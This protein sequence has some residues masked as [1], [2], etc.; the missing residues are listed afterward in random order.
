MNMSDA[1]QRRQILLER[2]RSVP[3]SQ[4][5]GET[6]TQQINAVRGFWLLDFGGHLLQKMRHFFLGHPEPRQLTSYCMD[7]LMLTSQEPIRVNHETV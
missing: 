5:Q 6:M 3:R 7:Y 1:M 4:R 2:R